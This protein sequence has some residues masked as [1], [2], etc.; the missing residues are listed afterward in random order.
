MPLLNGIVH[1]WSFDEE[2]GT[3]VDSIDAAHLADVNAVG[4][5]AGKQ[6]N[7]A[8]FVSASSQSLSKAS[9]VP[10]LGGVFTIALWWNPVAGADLY[11]FLTAKGTLSYGSPY[12]FSINAYSGRNPEFHVKDNANGD[13]AIA[14]GA[15]VST[16]VWH[17]LIAWLDADKIPRLQ[18]DG[19]TVRVGSS[20]LAG[21]P[22]SSA[23]GIVFGN[24]GGWTAYGGLMDEPLLWNRVLTDD[25]RTELLT[26][27]YPYTTGDTVQA[28]A[29]TAA[30]VVPTA[31][32][33]PGAAT[34][35]SLPSF[36]EWTVPAA[37]VS[38]VYRASATP[39]VGSWVV[40][41]AASRIDV[42][43]LGRV[44]DLVATTRVSA[45]LASRTV[46][47]YGAAT[48]VHNLTASR[49]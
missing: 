19:G 37:A 44:L 42:K 24:H 26:L 27:F 15:N 21:T 49:N 46:H 17:L 8:S 5:A 32:A 23:G 20:A 7:A 30:W 18:V 39:S 34:V 41:V 14:L 45:L 22:Y 12:E 31:A 25:E 47:N 2:S 48:T 10:N 13:V 33:V 40:P 38:S 35:V 11:T 43:E 16:G 6:N 3:R 29:A 4:F 28:T 9:G 36:A 1:R